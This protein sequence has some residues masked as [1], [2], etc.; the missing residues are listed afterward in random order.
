M[1]RKSK[2]PHSRSGNDAGVI[3]VLI[4]RFSAL[5]DV[6]MTIPVVYSACMCYPDVSFVF[7]TRPSMTSIFI[8][9]PANLQVVGADVKNDYRGVTGMRRLVAELTG[10]YR[11][12]VFIDLHNVLRTRLMTI[13][14]RLRGI[15]TATL[16]KARDARRALTRA[17]HKVMIP[18]VSQRARYREAFFKIGLPL[19]ERFSGLFE[20]PGSSDSAA[21]RAISA[22]KAPGE[23]WIGIAPFAAH[24]GKIYPPEM[25]EKVV[26]ALVGSPCGVSGRLKIFLLGGGDHEKEVLEGWEKRFPE[27]ITSLAGKRYGFPAELA[28]LNHMDLVVAMDSANMHLAAIAGAPTLSIWGATHPYCG[29]K[30]WR[31]KDSDTVQLNLGCRPCSVFGN[32]PCRE[33]SDYPC[34]SGI[35]PSA[36]FEKILAKVPAI[37]DDK[38]GIKK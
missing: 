31:Q 29:F 5:G 22:P 32:K 13:F 1:A 26:E 11:P 25:M 35:R 37:G 6:A 34:L 17:R 4:A 21:F 10:E 9:R 18:L 2:T 15:R 7:V 33:S 27:A 12:D 8:N 36:I 16:Y 19:T 20:G 38:A 23:V 30:A 3:S 28:L 24:P 14:C